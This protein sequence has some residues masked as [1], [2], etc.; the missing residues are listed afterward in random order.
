MSYCIDF[1]P[2]ACQTGMVPVKVCI[3]SVFLCYLRLRFC[4]SFVFVQLAVYLYCRLPYLSVIGCLL[5]IYLGSS[6][7]DFVCIKLRQKECTSLTLLKNK[8]KKTSKQQTNNNKTKSKQTTTKNLLNRL[9]DNACQNMRE[10]ERKKMYY[11]VSKC[12]SLM[13]K[14]NR[15]LAS[16]LLE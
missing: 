16:N 4:Y 13:G 10:F 11:N 9:K 8:S 1:P 14:R 15:T 12:C 3:T 7:L 6:P 5:V 2:A